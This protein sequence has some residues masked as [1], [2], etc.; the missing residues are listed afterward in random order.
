MVRS[1]TDGRIQNDDHVVMIIVII[2]VTL[3][4]IAVTAVAID[5]D[6]DIAAGAHA[7]DRGNSVVTTNNTTVTT[8][9]RL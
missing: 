6:I 5:I 3:A 4:G 2:V 9:V 8:P 1:T 7:N